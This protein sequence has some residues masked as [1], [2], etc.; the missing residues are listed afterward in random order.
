MLEN[1]WLNVSLSS[2]EAHMRFTGIE[3]LQALN[4]ISYEQL[5]DFDIESVMILGIAGGNG[6]MFIRLDFTQKDVL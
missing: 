4:R 1:A 3:Q 5:S 6:K 2:Y